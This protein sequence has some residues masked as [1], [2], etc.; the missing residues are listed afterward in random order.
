MKTRK[1][2]KIKYVCEVCQSEYDQ[3]WKAQECEKTHACKCKTFYYTFEDPDDDFIDLDDDG[4]QEPSFVLVKRCT[5][6]SR[7]D[8]MDVMPS[9]LENLW[10]TL[11]S[12][13]LMEEVNGNKD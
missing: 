3:V 9:D 5:D 1:Y 6:C 12:K 13:K 2:E 10:E 4:R 7:Y 11:T 8:S